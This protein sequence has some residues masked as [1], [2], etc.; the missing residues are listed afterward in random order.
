MNE[1]GAE[2]KPVAPECMEWQRCSFTA[3]A[4]LG[5]CDGVAPCSCW[6]GLL[7][8]APPARPVATGL[9]THPAQPGE[10]RVEFWGLG[11]LLRHS[12]MPSDHRCIAHK[13]RCL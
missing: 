2:H 3:A 10:S 5:A 6:E 9:Y 4:F 7:L 1:Q 13:Q 8:A 11:L 12:H